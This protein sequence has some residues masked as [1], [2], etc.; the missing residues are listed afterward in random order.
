MSN[1]PLWARDPPINPPFDQDM[2]IHRDEEPS[3][4]GYISA[5]TLLDVEGKDMSEVCNIFELIA[6]RPHATAWIGYDGYYHFIMER[7]V[8]AALCK[9]YGVKSRI[10]MI[11]F[12]QGEELEK[13][14]EECRRNRKIQHTQK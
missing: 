10:G 2:S 1:I 3:G 11:T 12:L 7:D 8:S 9:R 14:R 4:K 13:E 5:G 6:R